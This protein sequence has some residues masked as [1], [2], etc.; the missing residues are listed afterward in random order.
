[1]KTF[2]KQ[3]FLDIDG[4]L[5]DFELHVKNKFGIKISE[6]PKNEVPWASMDHD[7]YA[8][9][10]VFDGA[11][12][13]Y[14]RLR[15]FPTKF[16]SGTLISDGCWSGKAQWVREQM[17]RDSWILQDLMLCAS[18]AKF[19]VAGSNRILVDDREKNIDQWI[20]AGGI[21][22][23]IENPPTVETYEQAFGIINSLPDNIT[24]AQAFAQ[25]LEGAQSFGMMPTNRFE[26]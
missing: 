8:S 9:I 26:L 13:F 24:E 21:G 7:F 14:T 11:K 25:T 6:T 19:L 18:N 5:A 3:I 10:P 12:F 2:K 15:E 16:L 23:Y 1:M 4:V 22:I 20:E 17:G